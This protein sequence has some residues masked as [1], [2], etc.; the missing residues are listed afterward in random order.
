MGEMYR[1]FSTLIR[2]VVLCQW[3]LIVQ[4]SSLVWC[5][6]AAL[7]EKRP[8]LLSTGTTTGSIFYF[9]GMLWQRFKLM[10]SRAVEGHCNHYTTKNVSLISMLAILINYLPLQRQLRN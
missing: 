1:Q 9:F 3:H 8:V 7:G 10:T 4:L 5:D 2:S 6:R